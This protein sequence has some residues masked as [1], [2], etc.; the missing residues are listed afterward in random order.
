MP[1][2]ARSIFIAATACLCLG[3]AGAF[4][5]TPPPPPPPPPAAPPTVYVPTQA[6]PGTPAPP[7]AAAPG[8]PG[9]TDHD[10][11]VGR[12]GLEARQVGIFQRSPGNDP[13]C[14]VG[15]DCP[16]RF[17]AFS[18][19]RWHTPTYAWSAG[20]VLGIGGGSRYDMGSTKS[21][22]TY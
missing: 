2:P 15:G 19:R 8:E 10:L 9:A 5:Q 4:G 12:W 6:E 16:L 22:D 13:S 7:A 18:V 11:V 20:L 1:A 14:P 3:S 21:W 17:N